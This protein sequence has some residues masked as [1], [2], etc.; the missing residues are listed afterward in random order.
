MFCPVCRDEFRP[1][2]TRC[3]GCD[4]DLVES[5]GDPVEPEVQA[6]RDLM[7]DSAPQEPM[8]NFC[9]F[10][11]LEEA[12]AA[13]DKMRASG[14]KAEILICEEPGAPAS[15]TIKEEYWLRVMP[16]DFKAATA[17][18]GEDTAA[19]AETVEEDSFLCSAC[20]ATVRAADTKCPGC[21]L[22][23]E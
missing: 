9:G 12:R 7:A 10:M 5:L 2:F 14:R 19:V 16:R 22:S 17:L 3:A 11:T 1:G 21:G 23:F 4:V 8:T 6:V 20:G 15:A 18:V 13:R